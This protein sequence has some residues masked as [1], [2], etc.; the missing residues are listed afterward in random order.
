MDPNEEIPLTPKLDRP[1]DRVDG[2]GFPKMPPLFR[3]LSYQV[4]AE[5]KEEG[6][7]KPEHWIV[8]EA[9]GDYEFTPDEF[10]RAY[11]PLNHDA[12]EAWRSCFYETP[13]YSTIIDDG[14][15]GEDSDYKDVEDV[16]ETT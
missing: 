11:R 3:K 16:E 12:Y 10:H 4:N 8:H 2:P 9:D 14:N 5:F 6:S 1:L 13:Y 7:G 15:D